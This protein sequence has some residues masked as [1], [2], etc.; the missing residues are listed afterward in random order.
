M[1]CVYVAVSVTLFATL[2]C[3]HMQST[4]ANNLNQFLMSSLFYFKFPAQFMDG[5]YK[6]GRCN[7]HR[8]LHNATN[9]KKGVSE[10]E[11]ERVREKCV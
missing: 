10:N 11:R 1:R 6:M 9:I 3:L 2:N 8:H 5:K 4:T 7:V